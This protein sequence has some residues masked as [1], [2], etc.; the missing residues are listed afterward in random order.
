MPKRVTLLSWTAPLLSIALSLPLAAQESDDTA[1]ASSAEKTIRA[2]YDLVGAEAGSVPDWE[3]IR[4][5]FLPEAVVIL[6]SSRDAF[7]VLSLDGFIEDFDAFYATPQVQANGFR[8][9]ILEL[10]ATEYGDMAQVW[11][12]YEAVVPNA[13]GN[14]G[15]DNFSLVRRDGA[16][17]VAAITNEV[18]LPDR[19]VPADLFD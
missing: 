2:L 19:P 10:T 9:T 13:G 8:E 3:P 14:R 15:L 11:V 18:V 6:R 12:L 17:R 1:S 7:S 5:T 4:A 16:W